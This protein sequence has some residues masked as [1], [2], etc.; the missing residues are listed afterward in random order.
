MNKLLTV[1]IPMW[2]S[3]KYIAR[4]LLSLLNQPCAE[5]LQI[6]CIDDGSEDQTVCVC[7]SFADRYS[8]IQLLRRPHIGVSSARNAGLFAVRTPYLGFLDSDDC[9]EDNF[10]NDDILKLLDGQT[11][12]IGFG[13]QT[14][15]QDRTVIEQFSSKSI[16][17]AGGYPAVCA[18]ER[19]FASYLYRTDF[20]I[21]YHLTFYPYVQFNEDEAFR[22]LCLYLARE[23]RFSDKIIFS[24]LLRE[25]S[26]RHRRPQGVYVNHIFRIWEH[27]WYIFD[28]IAPDD[29][30]IHAYCLSRID[31]Y[32]SRILEQETMSPAVQQHYE[33]MRMQL[34]DL[35][36]RNK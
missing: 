6:L 8:Q 7:Q 23:I 25:D 11:D 10:W 20:L 30:E 24:N 19:H 35:E 2:N 13:W 31:K 21:H 32:M 4:T 18:G 34:E 1:I 27:V 33:E 3:E 26:L 36:C 16:C 5:A 17:M 9:W 29:A 14:A 22:T 12:L 15:N 28:I